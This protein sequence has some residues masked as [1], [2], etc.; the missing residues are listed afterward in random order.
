[1]R[2]EVKFEVPL[3]TSTWYVRRRQLEIYSSVQERVGRWTRT[4]ESSRCVCSLWVGVVFLRG[5]WLIEKDI[6]GDR[7]GSG[8]F[9]FGLFLF[10][11]LS[12]FVGLEVKTSG[13]EDND[14]PRKKFMG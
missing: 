3:P 11:D 7:S 8:I 12:T 2:E 6:R 1:M 10:Q 4:W 9:C 5:K 14:N 13:G